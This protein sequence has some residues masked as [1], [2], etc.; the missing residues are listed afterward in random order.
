VKSLVALAIVCAATRAYAQP[1]LKS[2]DATHADRAP[3]IDGVLDDDLWRTATFVSDFAE[4]EPVENGPPAHKTELAIAY[5]D[6]AIYVGAR[7]WSDGPD[8]VDAAVTRRD[9]GTQAERII[10]SF[11][12]FRSQHVAYSFAVSAGGTRLDWLHTDDDDHA[13]DYSWDPVWEAKTQLLAD[14]WSAEMRIPLGQLRYPRDARAWGVNF[15]RYIPHRQEDIFW[16]VVPKETR[17][18]PSWFGELRFASAPPPSRHVELIPYAALGVDLFEAPTGVLQRTARLRANAGLDARI[19]LGPGLTLGAT[20]NPDFGQVEADPAVVNLSAYEIR[21]PERRPFFIEGSQIF[22]TAG[23]TY[24]YSR[25]IGGLPSIDLTYDE[26]LPPTDVRILGAAKLSGALAPHTNVGALAAITDEA[27]APIVLGGVRSDAILAPRTAW[28]VARVEQDLGGAGATAGATITAVARDLS[29]PNLAMQLARTAITGGADLR[30]RPRDGR[31]E[32]K[33]DAGGSDVMGTAAAI[34]RIEET[35]T[36]YF[37]RPDQAHVHVDT[38]AT[39][40]RGWH[41]DAS[42]SKRAG[43]WLWDASFQAE[44]PGLELNDAGAIESADDL[45]WSVDLTRRETAPSQHLHGWSITGVAQ[46]GWNFGGVRK[47]GYVWID[48]SVTLPSFASTGGEIAFEYPGVL[49]DLTRGGPLMRGPVGVSADWSWNSTPNRAV[50]YGVAAHGVYTDTMTRGG[51]LSANLTAILSPRL[52]VQLAPRVLWDRVL[53]QYVDTIAGGGADTYGSRYLFAE[54]EQHEAAAQLRAQL[55]LSP[56]LTLEAYVEPFASVGR[57]TGLG[58]L[59]AARTKDLRRYDSFDR[60]NGSITVHD[61][62][63]DFTISDPDFTAVSLRSTVV[64][65]WELTPG[66][67]L[68]A[69]WQQNRSQT[70]A[71]ADPSF[72]SLGRPF[73]VPGEHLV[74]IKLTWWFAP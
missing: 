29:D 38:T 15:N 31:Y 68:Y 44:S 9:D 16:I 21:F 51:R 36:H 37:Q 20:I 42:A 56:D 8:D 40:L 39:S 54:L 1:P 59:A 63:G 52:R 72:H 48:W 22:A 66:S 53:S 33:L 43:R 46:G 32:L 4:K 35:S 41:L 55:A 7:M 50:V 70:D 5:D 64:L 71:F 23:H 62:S 13:R 30:L 49:D 17:A 65:R 6:G 73:S 24:F 3:V 45:D 34:T 27:T 14:G 11:D 10:V 26:L 57:Y 61:P 18:W 12:P 60:A 2:L 25:R 58:E 19:G 47:P 74:A 28:G 69:V 67:V